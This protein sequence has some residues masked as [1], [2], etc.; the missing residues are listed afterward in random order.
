M[1]NKSAQ[2][3]GRLSA[4][5]RDTSSEVMRALVNKRWN[6]NIEIWSPKYSTNEVLI[7]THR[8]KDGDN[9]I[10]FTKAKELIGN[11]YSIDGAKIRSFKTQKNGKATVHCVPMS[12][13]TLLT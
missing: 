11:V 1:K 9:K 5:S 8:V 10:V 13:L 2:A 3:L 12:E 4:K 7:A 6:M